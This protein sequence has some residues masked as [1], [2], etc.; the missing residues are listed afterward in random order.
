M[1]IIQQYIC[2]TCGKDAMKVGGYAVDGGY[3]HT[4]FCGECRPK[5]QVKEEEKKEPRKDSRP[6]RKETQKIGK[7][8]DTLQP[9]KKGAG[10][11]P[12]LNEKFIGAYGTKEIKNYDPEAATYY[13]NPKRRRKTF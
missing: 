8:K 6:Y 13:D 12:V 7:E 1:P 9:Y 10:G 11:K 5:P 4:V 2:D 3:L